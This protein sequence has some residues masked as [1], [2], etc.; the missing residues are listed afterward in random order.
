MKMIMNETTTLTYA[1]L[2]G[3]RKQDVGMRSGCSPN[4]SQISSDEKDMCSK[5]S[6]F[7]LWLIGTQH[8]KKEDC[9]SYSDAAIT[10]RC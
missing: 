2:T 9:H 10:T 7:G 5:K 8:Q 1:A 3:E 6:I 4:P